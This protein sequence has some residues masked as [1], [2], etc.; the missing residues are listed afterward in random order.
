M[1]LKKRRIAAALCLVLCITTYSVPHAMAADVTNAHSY[2]SVMPLMEFILNEN[3]DFT[4]SGKTASMYAYVEGRSASVT[5]CEI[6]I[7][8]QEKGVLS[9]STVETW[10][11]SKNSYKASLS[12]SHSVTSG[13]TYRMVAT[14]TAWNGSRSES[15][16]VTSD[17]VKA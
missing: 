12:T 10:S 13:K 6:S 3:H 9:W 16:T 7:K 11:T 1:S 14:I 5:K 8:L 17:A 4:I 15:K 2:S